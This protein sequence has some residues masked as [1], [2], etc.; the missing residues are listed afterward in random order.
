MDILEQVQHRA[1]KTIK[2]LEHLSCEGRLRE[3]GLFSL[4]K[5]NHR[6]DLINVCKYLMG[7]NKRQSQTLLSGAHWEDKR[8]CTQIASCRQIIPLQTGDTVPQNPTLL[9]NVESSKHPLGST[10]EKEVGHDHNQEPDL[11]QSEDYFYNQFSKIPLALDPSCFILLGPQLMKILIAARE[12]L[13]IP[14]DSNNSEDN[15][16]FIVLTMNLLA[17]CDSSPNSYRNLA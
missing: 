11:T 13:N 16:N 1:M 2:E 9:L 8:Q 14:A 12:K 17:L 3:L 15:P 5:R 6:G 7:E 4:K 10:S